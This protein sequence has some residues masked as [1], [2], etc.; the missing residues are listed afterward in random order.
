[1]KKKCENSPCWGLYWRFGREERL[2]GSLTS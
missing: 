1:M 2:L